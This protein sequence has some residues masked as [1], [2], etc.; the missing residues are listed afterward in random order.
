MLITVQSQRVDT[1]EK[2]VSSDS[3]RKVSVNYRP[4]GWILSA[5]KDAGFKKITG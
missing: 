4:G 1:E 2:D 3:I 5:L